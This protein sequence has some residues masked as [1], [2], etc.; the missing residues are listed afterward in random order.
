M[1]FALSASEISTLAGGF[2]AVVAALG[3]V[4]AA[5]IAVREYELKSKAQRVEIDVQLSQ[6][7]AELV[8]IANGR[9]GQTVSEAAAEA[10]AK[11]RPE[12][13]P[14]ELHA[15][16]EAA[17]LTMPI[18]EAT[19]AAAITSISYLGTE[20]P[21]LR[22]SSRQALQTLDFVDGRPKL[23]AAREEA[24]ARVRAAGS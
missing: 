17:V 13:D 14:E 9:G 22:A 2:A 5:W 15:A 12:A 7:L 3:G 6:L 1:V 11:S 20:H 21:A 23:R 16:L 8:P 18:G 19:Q 24:L 4:R 10:I